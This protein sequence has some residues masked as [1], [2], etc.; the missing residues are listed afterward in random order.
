MK[1]NFKSIKTMCLIVLSLVI[2]SCDNKNTQ[3]ETAMDHDHAH[4]DHEHNYACPMHPEVVGHEGE[5]CHKCGMP[6]EKIS[7]NGNESTFKMEFTSSPQQVEAGKEVKLSFTPKNVSA[8]TSPVP[9]DVE[10]EKKIHLILV[11]EDLSWF[12]HIHPEYQQDGSYIVNE[13]FPYG[14]N[15]ILFADYKPTGSTHQ[16]E[17]INLKVSGNPAPSSRQR[18]E[19]L[20]SNVDGYE[21]TFVNGRELKT[22]SEG[23]MIIKITKDGK[24]ISGNDLEK[25]LGSNA[26]IV[27]VHLEDK[28][29]I[30]VHPEANEYPIHAHSYFDKA[31]TYV[32]WVQFQTNGKIHTADFLVNVAEGNSTANTPHDHSGHQH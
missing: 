24:E 19:K 15:Y 30:H 14:G 29:Y 8:P 16:L 28:D 6:L 4:G 13:T 5:N 25:Y 1:N 11:N 10:H 7:S 21:V 3:T 20:N 9:L 23:H 22:A 31:G 32:M 17:K 26:H 18:E 27:M 12:D 2:A